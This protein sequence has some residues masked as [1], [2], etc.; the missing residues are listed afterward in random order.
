MA[1]TSYATLQASIG[2]WLNRSDLSGVIPDFIALAE[3]Q[4]NRNIRHRKMVARATAPLVF[5]YNAVPSDWL[6]TIRYQVNSNPVS[7]MEFVAPEQASLLRVKYS[8]PGRPLFYTQIGQQFQVIPAPD[9]N[10]TYVGE[11]TYYGKIPA[12]SNLNTSN[13]LLVEA[14]DLYLYASLLQSAPY[15]KDDDRIATWAGLYER[16]LNDLSISD[17]RSRMA[18]SSLRMRS[19]SFG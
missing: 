3:A 1:I 2:D 6:E 19:K 12:L 15:L 10:S 9:S 7:V 14:P 13:W 5:E 11:L 17:E 18:T 4:F 8:A 16:L